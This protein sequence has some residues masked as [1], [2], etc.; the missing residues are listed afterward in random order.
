MSIIDALREVAKN[1]YFWIINSAGWIG[2]L[3]SAYGVILGWSFVYSHN[4]E[5]AAQLGLAN[6]VIG[7]AALWSMILAPVAIKKLGK[8]NLLII[9]NV[10]NVILFIVMFFCFKNLFAVCVI[11]FLNGFFNT[12]GNIYFPN[13]NADM[14][15]YH[16]WKT[17]VRIDGLF[18]PLGLI[19]TVL[20]FFTGLVVPAIYEKM[21]I[22]DDYN[23]LYNDTLRNNLFRVLLICSIIGAILNLIPYLF[24]DLTEN[25]HQGYV[26]VLKIRAM[27][28][29][30]GD[31]VLDDDE[32]VEAMQIINTARELDGAQK[33]EID[34]SSLSAAKAMPKETDDEKQKRKDAIRA[35]R[36]KIREI[37]E[38]NDNL[39]SM[40]IVLEELNKFSTLRY[41]KQLDAAY[42]VLEHRE[43]F[44]YSDAKAEMKAAKDLPKSTKEERVIRA[45]AIELA[46]IKRESSKLIR[47]YGFENLSVPDESV[48]E[49]IQTRE[50]KTLLES[51]KA[52][53]ELKA[54]VK[55]VS[56]YQRVTKPYNR[57]KNLVIQSENYNHLAEIEQMYKD[58]VSK[59]AEKETV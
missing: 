46:R 8:R 33:T 18:G 49:E 15:D 6:T 11:L 14:R 20:G 57:A 5:K 48:K 32:L 31:G 27:F 35:E 38:R 21:G 24:Y 4:G 26:N 52:R 54:F 1:K 23:V 56:I 51:L 41:R 39:E 25:K 30:Y 22:H 42:K 10:M 45:D 36:K 7:N 59:M 34:K 58:V 50:T 12:F 40:P 3:E 17:G 28:E 2:F 16:Q 55:S 37:K 29:D 13:I 9:N 44:D 53:R 19:G 47:K 43:V